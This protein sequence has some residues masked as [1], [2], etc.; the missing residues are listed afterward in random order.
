MAERLFTEAETCKLI[1]DAVILHTNRL[2]HHVTRTLT[3]A[4]PLTTHRDAPDEDF[5]TNHPVEAWDVSPPRQA[6]VANGR[7]QYGE[8]DGPSNDPGSW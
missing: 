5:P 7:S 8:G 1:R 2:M 3:T 4:A 6:H